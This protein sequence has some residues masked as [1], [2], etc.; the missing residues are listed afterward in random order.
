MNPTQS[1]SFR[2]TASLHLAAF[3]FFA[4][5]GRLCADAMLVPQRIDSPPVIDGALDDAVWRQSLLI[6]DFLQRLPREGAEPAERTEVRL[7]YTETS[8]YIGVRAFDNQPQKLASTVMKR[9]DFDVTQND[10][11]AL[12]IDSYNDGR[13]GYWFSTNPLGVRVDAQFAE[14]GDWWESNWNG[15]WECKARIDSQGWTAEIE[16]PFATLRFRKAPSNVMGINFFRRVIATN[17]ALFFPLIPLRYGNGTPNVSVARKYRFDSIRGANQW[18]IKP[19]GLGG[20]ADDRG[21]TSSQRNAGLDLRYQ[22][23]TS[24]ITNLSIKTDFTETEVDDRQINLTRFSLFYPEKRDFFLESSGNFQFGLA[25]DTELFFSRRI[26]LSDDATESLPMLF[27]AKLTGK[28]KTLDLGVLDAQTES[29][30]SLTAEN[31]SVLRAKAA[32]GK[33][34]FAGGI[35]TNRQGE[36]GF[37]RAYGGD[38]NLYVYRDVFLNAFAAGVSSSSGSSPNG[39]AAFSAALG[40]QSDRTSFRIGYRDIGAAFD[41]AIGFVQKSDVKRAEA[42]LS[43]PFYSNSPLLQ[44]VTPGCELF[45]DHDHS[46][47][48]SNRYQQITLKTTF[49]SGD[50]FTLFADHSDELVPQPFPVYRS[51]EIPAGFYKSARAGISAATKDGRAWSGTLDFSAGDFYGGSRL[52]ASPTL[53]WKT[54]RHL[55]LSAT[56]VNDWIEVTNDRFRIQLI[57]GRIGYSLNTHLSVSSVV[58]YDNS[59]QVLGVNLRVGYLL[60]EGTELF[61]VYNGIRDLATTPEEASQKAGSLLVKFTYLFGL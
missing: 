36:S 34:S 17:E 58:Q 39:S 1:L 61:V 56:Y 43:V 25:G 38:L 41:P 44:S 30:S 19:Y 53:L 59:S 52:E 16:I 31:F 32:L 35:F 55:T 15:I 23:T 60:R 48:L 13:S 40:R 7:L 6:S 47:R 4:A 49:Q 54:N 20:L 11:F 24:L 37:S 51:V 22:I 57:R 42:M 18:Y 12:A 14:E 5:A 50:Q 26:G 46:G 27:G 28:V 10:Q 29:T 9:D 33:R 21:S 8:L 2:F 45:T 3:L